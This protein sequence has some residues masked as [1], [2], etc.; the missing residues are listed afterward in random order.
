MDNIPEER[1]LIATKHQHAGIKLLLAGRRR[2]ADP[3]Y[4]IRGGR[5]VKLEHIIS[6]K[7]EPRAVNLL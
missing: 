1:V 7:L 4:P 6:V 3:W 2:A 5:K